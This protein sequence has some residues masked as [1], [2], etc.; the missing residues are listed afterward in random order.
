MSSAMVYI[1]T[2]TRVTSRTNVIDTLASIRPQQSKVGHLVTIVLVPRRLKIHVIAAGP[3]GQVLPPAA[4]VINVSKVDA[5]DGF[6]KVLGALSDEIDI[7]AGP[8]RWIQ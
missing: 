8:I 7:S 6:G 4:L 2:H 3:F 5:C 1:V